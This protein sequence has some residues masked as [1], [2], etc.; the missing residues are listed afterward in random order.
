MLGESGFAI[1]IFEVVQ[2]FS[3]A[4]VERPACLFCVFCVAGGAGDLVNSISLIFTLLGRGG[5][6]GGGVFL[7]V[8]PLKCFFVE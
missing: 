2:L 3:E 8:V 4:G 5:G 6:G 1:S 7:S